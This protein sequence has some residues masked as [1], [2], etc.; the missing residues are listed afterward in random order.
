MADRKDIIDQ[1][2]NDLKDNLTVNNGYNIQPIEV[3][4]GIHQW[5]DFPHL[6]VICFTV[7][8]DE[9]WEDNEHGES[10][11]SFNMTIYMYADTDGNGN[12]DAINDM[13][14]DIQNFLKNSSHFTYYNSC[15]VGAIE[16]REGGINQEKSGAWIEIQIVYDSDN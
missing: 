14:Y 5:N 4:K 1:I 16:I 12:S 10:I 13:V 9:P 2:E 6:P 7:T 11:R 3:R 15:L 8:R